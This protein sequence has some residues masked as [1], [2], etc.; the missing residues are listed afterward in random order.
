MSRSTR[1]RRRARSGFTLIEVLVALAIIAV[2]LSG[3]GSLVATSVRGTRSLDQRIAL[4]E[5]ARAIMNGLPSRGDLAPGNF[6]G[7]M[8]GHR[9]RVD[10]LP[11]IADFVD[12]RQQPAWLPQT[13]LIT[14]Q[15]ATGQVFRLSTVRLRKNEERRADGPQQ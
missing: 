10:V 13:V 12:P 7:E 6:S 4:L 11:F 8:A 15:S 1:S 9:W 5:T 3:I 14:V 2:S